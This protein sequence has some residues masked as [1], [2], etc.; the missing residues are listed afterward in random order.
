MS[1][2]SSVLFSVAL[3]FAS[4]TNSFGNENASEEH[5][6]CR[7]WAMCQ[8]IPSGQPG[9]GMTCDYYGKGQGPDLASAAAA[10][11]NDAQT[12]CEESCTRKTGNSCYNLNAGN[13][14]LV[15][16]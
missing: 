4:L 7:G 9:S 1:K 10:A 11:K 12:N 2:L 15:R 8:C 6:E 5:Y 14:E 16:P 3:A 13:C